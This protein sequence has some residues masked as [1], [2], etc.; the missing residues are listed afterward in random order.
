MKIGWTKAV[1]V[2]QNCC[3]L[4]E[5]VIFV[6]SDTYFVQNMAGD[7]CVCIMN[8]RTICII[9]VVKEFCIMR[10]REISCIRV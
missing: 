9:F 6:L 4:Y 5:L 2:F 10:L 3:C 1:R 8:S 7:Q